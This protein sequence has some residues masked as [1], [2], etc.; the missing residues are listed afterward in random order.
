M[1]AGTNLQIWYSLPEIVR[2]SENITYFVLDGVEYEKAE[3]LRNAK[4][5]AQSL[6]KLSRF[7]NLG[8]L[9]ENKLKSII[10]GEK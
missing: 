1:S 5:E 10:N 2:E 4:R 9:T 8:P 3:I 7:L 6:L